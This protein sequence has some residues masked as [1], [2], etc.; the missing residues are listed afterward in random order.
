MD[1]RQLLLLAGGNS[2]L[3][4]K[5]VD[6]LTAQEND[7]DSRIS[8]DAVAAYLAKQKAFKEKIKAEEAE[9]KKRRVQARLDAALGKPTRKEKKMVEKEKAIN[10][11]FLPGDKRSMDAEKAKMKERDKERL[12]ASKKT[13]SKYK[14]RKSKIK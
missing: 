2:A 5:K 11:H 9:A 6:R 3:A 10:G 14:W 13:T 7:D 8:G 12:K 1:V 4:K